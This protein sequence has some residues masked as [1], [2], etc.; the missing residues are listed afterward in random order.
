M[1]INYVVGLKFKADEGVENF[2][3]FK[4][5]DVLTIRQKKGENIYY[6]INKDR[7]IYII[8]EKELKEMI[9]NDLIRS[10]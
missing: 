3:P 9:E 2:R 8:E 4:M 7:Q 10:I 1:K 5:D 6:S